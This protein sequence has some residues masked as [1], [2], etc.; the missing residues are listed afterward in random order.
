MKSTH[1]LWI[2]R[3]YQNIKIN[4]YENIVFLTQYNLILVYVIYVFRK[5]GC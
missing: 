5:L 4:I 2:D 1:N 3:Y